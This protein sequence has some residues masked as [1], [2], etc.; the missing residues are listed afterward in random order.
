MRSWRTVPLPLQEVE[1]CVCASLIFFFSI[2]EELLYDAKVTVNRRKRNRLN[3]AKR[4]LMHRREAPISKG[5]W[6]GE[7][8]TEGITR[9]K[10]LFS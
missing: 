8:V 1:A 10:L 5:S 3:S 4:K 2:R 6:H 9:V 7:A